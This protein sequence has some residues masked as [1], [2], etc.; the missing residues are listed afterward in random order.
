MEKLKGVTGFKRVT[1]TCPKCGCTSTVETDCL[2]DAAA[3]AQHKCF[4][5]K[6]ANGKH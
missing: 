4:G 3:K 5:G 6:K 1:Y 2:S